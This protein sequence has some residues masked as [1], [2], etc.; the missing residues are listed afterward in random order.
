[1]AESFAT[2]HDVN[3]AISSLRSYVDSE[4]KYTRKNID[5]LSSKLSALE[6][7]VETVK[8]DIWKKLNYLEDEM[9]YNRR[10]I[11]ELVTNMDE[12]FNILKNSLNKV[13][14]INER[15]FSENT[16]DN[17]QIAKQ[18]IYSSEKNEAGLKKVSS[19]VATVEILQSKAASNETNEAIQRSVEE[20]E[21]RYKQ[22]Q[23]AIKE[24]QLLFD[25]HFNETM[26][27][28]K[29][30]LELISRHIIEINK[31]NFARLDE[32]L[33]NTNNETK[34]FNSSSEVQIKK[35]N[36]RLLHFENVTENIDQNLKDLESFVRLRKEL[37]EF[38]S[39][40][41]Y[42]KF[43]NDGLSQKDN[44]AMS[45]PINLVAKSQ[46]EF[47]IFGLEP[48]VESCYES[49]II[50]NDTSE[51]YRVLKKNIYNLDFNLEEDWGQDEL[52]GIVREGLENL[53]STGLLKEDHFQ[54]INRHLDLYNLKYVQL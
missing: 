43:S 18:L 24:K 34:E 8:K 3:S 45:I 4:N 37:D 20:V 14:E 49:P 19:G 29:E 16:T 27:G 39:D 26:K 13:I 23:S 30:E 32:L 31:D 28:L 50:D 2:H 6:K 47:E 7:Y 46:G 12:K 22:A 40:D 17:K 5:K 54:L 21:D 51:L 1:M 52:N 36:Q 11:A 38:M 41:S 53:K 10:A 25:K 48:S 44:V 35:I 9:N 42:L 15:G 33:P